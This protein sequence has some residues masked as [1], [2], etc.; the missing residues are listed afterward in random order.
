MSAVKYSIEAHTDAATLYLF[1]DL[2][3]NE[4][5]YLRMALSRLPRAVQRLRV[6]ARRLQS[7]A[8]RTLRILK[9]VIHYWRRHRGA[10]IELHAME[11]LLASIGC[12]DDARWCVMPVENTTALAG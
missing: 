8:P 5:A 12:L 6:D 11:R 7:A 3:A 9:S 2:G 1:D 10:V 4:E